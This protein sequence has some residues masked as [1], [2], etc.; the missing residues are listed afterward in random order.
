MAVEARRT[1]K[2]STSPREEPCNHRKIIAGAAMRKNPVAQP[3]GN[4]GMREAPN[5]CGCWRNAVETLKG[6]ATSREAGLVR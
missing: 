6:G 5:Q 4:K 1:L 2:K 3:V